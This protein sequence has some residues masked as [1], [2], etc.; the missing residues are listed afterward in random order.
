MTYF[1]TGINCFR[2]KE[3]LDKREE[4]NL[5]CE[6]SITAYWCPFDSKIC[7]YESEQED[8]KF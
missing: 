3:G 1:G 6:Y 4:K 5:T 7:V 2:E 8:L